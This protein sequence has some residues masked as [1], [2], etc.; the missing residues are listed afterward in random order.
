MT[1]RIKG[2]LITFDRDIRDD[3]AEPIIEALKMIKGVFVVKPY[4][5][6]AEDYMLYHK[7]H[8]DARIAMLKFLEKDSKNPKGN[9]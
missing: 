3:D 5:S 9:D 7:G 1:D 6:G 4:I 8:M 2:V